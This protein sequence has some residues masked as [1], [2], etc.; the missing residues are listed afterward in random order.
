[1]GT[2]RVANRIQT[3][4]S[5]NIVCH[6]GNITA[7]AGITI[8]YR[9]ANWLQRELRDW[10]GRV[11]TGNK[12]YLGNQ[13]SGVVGQGE[14]S[15][16]ISGTGFAT[17]FS[18]GINCQ[19][20]GVT[21]TGVAGVTW[22]GTGADIYVTSSAASGEFDYSIDFTT[23][24]GVDTGAQTPITKNVS[25]RGL[26]EGAHI[27]TIT[28]TSGYVYLEGIRCFNG[29]E[30]DGIFVYNGGSIVVGA[31]AF[32]QLY[33]PKNTAPL[34]TV[35]SLA[36]DAFVI[37]MGQT[38]AQ[39]LGDTPAKFERDY[40]TLLS[41]ISARWPEAPI[42]I[43]IRP[44][45]PT[46][47]IGNWAEYKRVILRH[48][49]I[50]GSAIIDGDEVLGP[51]TTPNPY[52]FTLGV[53]TADGAVKLWG[54]VFNALTNPALSSGETLRGTGEVNYINQE[55]ANLR[56]RLDRFV[57]SSGV[58]YNQGAL[59]VNNA[60]VK[61]LGASTKEDSLVSRGYLEGLAE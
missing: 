7:G 49:S 18:A 10:S 5:A 33:P 22:Y 24:I 2:S 9:L 42:I 52:H 40:S 14:D 50:F 39:E 37:E 8:P 1:M 19:T 16:D 34:G 44:T 45:P 13:D 15:V 48:G 36:P 6:G 43:L 55:L 35:E 29:D 41:R 38:E 58:A 11:V 31:E 20:I 51:F 47:L 12:F 21:T 3:G 57:D 60:T 17:A 54:E 46:E 32:L 53:P 28:P 4:R 26:D 59:D 56:G 27:L 25:I 61:N 30:H 23:G